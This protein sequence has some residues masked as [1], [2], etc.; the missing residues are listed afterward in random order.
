[1]CPDSACPHGFIAIVMDGN[2]QGTVEALVSYEQGPLSKH[3]AESHGATPVFPSTIRFL[4]S[5]S[6]KGI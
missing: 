2:L 1:M 4:S 3:M 5:K 6:E